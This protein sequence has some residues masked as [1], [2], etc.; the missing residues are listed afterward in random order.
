M[1]VSYK[2]SQALLLLPLV[3]VLVAVSAQQSNITGRN[4]DQFT[5]GDTDTSGDN[6]I[7]GPKDW[8]KI[9]CPNPDTCVSERNHSGIERAFFWITINFE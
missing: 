5:Y 9:Q 3:V 2:S 6:N 7:Y 8:G 1:T 4:L